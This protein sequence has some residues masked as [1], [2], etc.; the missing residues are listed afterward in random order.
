[1]STTETETCDWPL[2]DLEPVICDLRAT[3][4]ILGHLITA[5]SAHDNEVNDDAF[6]KVES[7]LMDYSK[8]IEELWHLAWDKRNAEMIAAEAEHAAALAAVR[9]EKAAPGSAETVGRADAVWTMLRG[10]TA[11]MAEHCVEAGYPPRRFGT[12]ATEPGTGAST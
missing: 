5:N 4:E 9:A 8:R 6:R 12:P 1:M 2:G 7:D 11:V 10:L 3:V